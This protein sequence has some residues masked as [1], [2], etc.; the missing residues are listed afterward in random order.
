M[1]ITRSNR[2]EVSTPSAC[3][4]NFS[5]PVD[6]IWQKWSRCSSLIRPALMITAWK[7]CIPGIEA[8]RVDN[9]AR[10]DVVAVAQ[11]SRTVFTRLSLGWVAWLSEQTRSCYSIYHVRL[12]R[13]IIISGIGKN[14]WILEP[15]NPV[16]RANCEWHLTRTVML[17]YVC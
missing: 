8:R 4:T 10:Y 1:I 13:N 12:T 11:P 7:R 14:L 9:R 6:V 2:V 3:V 16:V 17:F 5:L 15:S